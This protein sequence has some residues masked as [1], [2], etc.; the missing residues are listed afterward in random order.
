[1]L[2][3]ALGVNSTCILAD[4]IGDV[5]R[6]LFMQKDAQKLYG[7]SNAYAFLDPELKENV[8]NLDQI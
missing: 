2:I 5:S 1:M 6:S 3:P 4:K 8:C 7:F